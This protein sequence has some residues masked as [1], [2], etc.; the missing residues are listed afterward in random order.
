MKK[1]KPSIQL[2]SIAVLLLAFATACDKTD[3]PGGD[4]PSAGTVKDADGNKYNTVKI[5]TQVWTVENLKTTKYNDGTPIPNV[6][7]DEWSN[8]T[9]GAYCNYDNLESN[10]EIYGRLYNWYAV[11]TG[12]LAP[13]GWH[14]PTDD[15]WA[16]LENCLIAIGYNYDGT[17]EGNKIAKSLCAKTNWALSSEAG[18][19]G[20]APENNNSTGFTALP[21]GYRRSHYGGFDRIGKSGYWWRSTVYDGNT[22]YYRH[23]DYD[24]EVLLRGLDYKANGFSVRLVR[25]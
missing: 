17:L 13:A 2:L 20:A 4:F 6:P 24:Y 21:G 8:L 11:N 18:T 14:V 25:D 10:A 3:D 1:R 5:G 16:I 9:T 22:A 19:P 7:D 23:L 15:D 12:K